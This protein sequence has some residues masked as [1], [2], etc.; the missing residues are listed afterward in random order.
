MQLISKE[1]L[2]LGQKIIPLVYGKNHEF[3]KAVLEYNAKNPDKKIG[4]VKFT[5]LIP[6]EK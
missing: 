6:N 3:K 5:P 4:L 2:V 1:N